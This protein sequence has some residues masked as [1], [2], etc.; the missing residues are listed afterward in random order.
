M[1]LYIGKYWV[2]LAYKYLSRQTQ[3]LNKVK[4]LTP[5]SNDNITFYEIISAANVNNFLAI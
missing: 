1:Y 3:L 4:T 5:A 2:D